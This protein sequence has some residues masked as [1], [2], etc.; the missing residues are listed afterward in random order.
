MHQPRPTPRSRG[1]GAAA[2]A[3]AAA[4]APA[5]AAGELRVYAVSDLHTDYAEN[6]EWCRRLPAARYRDAV[7]LVAGDVSDSPARLEETLGA[8]A[9]KFAAVFFV[10]GNHEH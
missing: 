5:A 6:L 7:L 8:L 1:P 3:P 10:N 2:A 9:A 4:T